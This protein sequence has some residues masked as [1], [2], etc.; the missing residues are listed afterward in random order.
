MNISLNIKDL[1]HSKHKIKN[2]ILLTF[3]FIFLTTTGMYTLNYMQERVLQ[4]NFSKTTESVSSMWKMTTII[5]QETMEAYLKYYILDDEVLRLFESASDPKKQQ[6]A[7]FKL[8][9]HLYNRYVNLRDKLFTRQFNFILPDN[10]ML[11][12]FHAPDKYG[13]DLSQARPSVVYVNR[14][15]KPFSGI[16]M[17]KIVFGYRYIFPVFNRDGKYLGCVELSRPF[18]IIR[19]TLNM[20][21]TVGDY[22]MLIN[23]SEIDKKVFHDYRGYY[24]TFA[25]LNDWLVENTNG[26]LTDGPKPMKEEYLEVVSNTN[27]KQLLDLPNDLTVYTKH[28]D[29]Y[30]KITA[31]KF[32]QVGENKKQLILLRVSTANDVPSVIETFNKFKITYTILVGLISL[33]IFL[34][35]N[36][37]YSIKLKNKELEL[38]T[39]TMGSG[40][41]ILD[42]DGFIK[43]INP[44]ATNILGFS[45]ED[46]VGNSFHELVHQH[47]GPKEACPIFLA[48][49]HQKEYDT[50]DS[51]KTKDGRFVDVSL[52]LR[53]LFIDNNYIGVVVVFDD[54]TERKQLEKRLFKMATED[55]LTDLYNR[56]YTIESL[57]KY[58]SQADRYGYSLSVM[59]IDIDDFKKINDTYGH[60]IGDEVLKALAKAIKENVRSSDIP[61]RWGGEEFLV[62]LPNTN[63]DGAVYLAERIRESI[64]QIQV[65]PVKRFTV[66]IGVSQYKFGETV[67]EFITTADRGLYEAKRSGK[68]KVVAIID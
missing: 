58:K 63:L 8:Y 68:N 14:E 15:K 24:T 50:D 46:L 42:K 2:F 11:I 38:I 60:D 25:G 32:S 34:Y 17:G 19:R 62:V 6:Y 9:K 27:M 43:F 67:D 22:V 59:M 10:T 18:E 56:R 41:V 47:T 7:R 51:F 54:I 35:L 40:L 39:A 1:S 21:D 5:H 52:K 28:K 26:R 37:N 29:K 33:G 13:D 64:S 23:R 55:P 45:K 61:S 44:A 49:K 66:S 36:K 20:I 30:Y 31:I 12:R 3:V 65:G 4:E 57:L 48:V 16:E 53:P